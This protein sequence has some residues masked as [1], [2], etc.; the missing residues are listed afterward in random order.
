MPEIKPE[1]ETFAKI[2]VVGVGGSGG[3]A[4]NRMINAN[5]KG[6]E[7]IVMNTDA[8]ALHNSLASKKVQ[9]GETVSRGLG[10]GMDP[11]V[12]A[13]AAEESQN[14][15]RE[16]IKGADMI[17]LACGLGGGTGSG[18]APKVAEI[19]REMGIL[20]VAVVTKPFQFE[21]YQRKTIAEEAA[22]RLTKFVDTI[23]T[24]PNDKILQIIDRKTS[25]IDAF[26]TV[27]DVLRQ[28]V[29]GISDIISIP[30]F[31]NVDFADVRAIMEDQGPALMGIGVGHGDNRAVDAAK[32]AIASP[33][34]EISMKGAQGV[35]FNITGGENLSMFE[36]NE[37]AQIIYELADPQVKLI[38]GA[39]TDTNL[40]DDEVRVTV[41][42]TG[43]DK[44]VKK[45]SREDSLNNIARH[46]SVVT[47]QVENNQN[48]VNNNQS[49]NYAA[50]IPRVPNEP[51]QQIQPTA[52][53][54]FS[55][56]PVQDDNTQSVEFQKPI[57]AP[58]A[59]VNSYQQQEVSAP[60]PVEEEPEQQNDSFPPPASHQPH[61]KPPVYAPIKDDINQDLKAPVKTVKSKSNEDDDV[62]DIPAWF[63]KKMM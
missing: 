32:S 56:T 18:A 48:F 16:A 53:Q 45:D 14:E 59:P 17:F 40:K 55:P 43:F 15:V 60:K 1:I 19:A 22:E 7:F 61:V 37:A 13:R 8:Q 39:I 9:L 30:G 3:S 4:V 57:P 51:P 31:I 23:I 10:A 34:L 50:S 58:I 44:I 26:N 25:L 27:D 54:S 29:Q 36:V 49:V 52:S 42:A 24:I 46:D 63:R 35:L 2:K 21:G 6:V 28:G 5:I 62:A 20:T 47:D 33:L 11:L 41:I 12:G 38:L